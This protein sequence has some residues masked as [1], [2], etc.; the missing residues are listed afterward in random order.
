VKPCPD[1]DYAHVIPDKEQHCGWRTEIE[2]L[3]DGKV[4]ITAYHISPYSK[5]VKATVTF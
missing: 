4:F 1:K 5:E 2:L 3:K